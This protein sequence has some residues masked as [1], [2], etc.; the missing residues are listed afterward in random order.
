METQKEEFE[1]S[2][3]GATVSA[4]AKICPN[5]GAILE[6]ISEEQNFSKEEFI[7]IPISSDPI[8]LST[9]ESL[10]KANKI[11]YSLNENI[12]DPVFGFSNN[13][14][15]KLLVPKD[16]IEIVEKIF[17]E[18]EGKTVL[19]NIVETTGGFET[20]K[21]MDVKYV[22]EE[23][24]S[25][26]FK[27]TKVGGYLFFFAFFL[28]FLLPLINLPFNIYYFLKIRDRMRWLSELQSISEIV[29]VI[30]IIIVLYSIYVGILIMI[31]HPGAIVYA[32]RF[33]TVYLVYSL[34]TF[35]TAMAVI[36]IR[37]MQYNSM[38]LVLFKYLF[39]FTVISIF[40][41]VHW[42]IYLHKSKRVKDTFTIHLN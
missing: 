31:K 33:L 3:C 9:I 37:D 35:F 16:K 36:P 11:D 20:D 25:E 29:L 30:S 41:I 24:K 1:C 38:V 21:K 19:S 39:R 2:N 6:E 14:I 7:E 4:D 32:N 28:I 12:I 26:D 10:L 34:L 23:K 18:Y 42:K 27:R 40:I 17:R 8:T 13:K 22:T 5:C 15:S